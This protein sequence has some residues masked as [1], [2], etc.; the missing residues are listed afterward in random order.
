MP[1]HEACRGR[2]DGWRKLESAG[3]PVGTWR[4]P[5][6]NRCRRRPA[7]IA[8][9]STVTSAT[10]LAA[11][12][13]QP[14]AR[15]SMARRRGAPPAAGV[16]CIGR[17]HRPRAT[18]RT[19]GHWSMSNGPECQW[20]RTAGGPPAPGCQG[21]ERS[22]SPAVGA[23][24]G[25]GAESPAPGARPANGRGARAGVLVAEGW[26]RGRKVGCRRRDGS[27]HHGEVERVW[28]RRSECRCLGSG[29]Q[30]KHVGPRKKDVPPDL[31]ERRRDRLKSWYTFKGSSPSL[32]G[33]HAFESPSP[34]GDLKRAVP[35]LG[36]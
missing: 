31:H 7:L 16:P 10:A 36:S 21:W 2:G 14:M 26:G 27:R 11:E 12:L 30:S 17:G 28:G 24:G 13:P 18:A 15:A 8:L 25:R 20:A 22:G 4:A 5:A 3:E 29:R 19:V 35:V 34:D 23:K 6:G 33:A 32:C 1:V 9:A